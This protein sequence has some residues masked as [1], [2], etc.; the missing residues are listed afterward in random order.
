MELLEHLQRRIANMARE[1]EELSYEEGL[2]E[3]RLLSL[4]KR[5]LW[6]DLRVALQCLKGAYKKAGE[7]LFTRGC[8]D[9]TRSDGFKLQEG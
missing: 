8:S 4:Q 1:L 3:L 5:K 2:R 7:G 6:Q 9:R